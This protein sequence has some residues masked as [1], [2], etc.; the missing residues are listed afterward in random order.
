MCHIERSVQ[1]ADKT[2]ELS[3]YSRLGL[4]LTRERFSLLSFE[5]QTNLFRGKSI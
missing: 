2:G 1:A 5:I 3:R 4:Y